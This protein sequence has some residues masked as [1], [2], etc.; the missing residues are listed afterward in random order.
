MA[1]S[2]PEYEDWGWYLEYF[3]SSGSEF[4][5]HCSNIGGSKDHWLLSLRRHARKLFGRDKPPFSEASELVAEI[6]RLLES[7]PSVA[8][9]KWLCS[10]EVAG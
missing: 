1:T 7:E 6:Q 10:E 3:P 8:S 4:A 2:Y 5:V 9:L